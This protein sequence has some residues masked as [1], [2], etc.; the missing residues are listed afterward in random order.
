VSRTRRPPMPLTGVPAH[1]R[2]PPSALPPWAASGG[3]TVS[4]RI[5]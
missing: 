5:A 2:W 1:W 3:R 4:N